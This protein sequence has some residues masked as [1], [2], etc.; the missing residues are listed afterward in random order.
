VDIGEMK[1]A[2]INNVYQIDAS[3]KVPLHKHDSNDELFY[4]VSGSGLEILEDSE[5]ELTIGKV[6]VVPAG[7][8]HAM[9]TDTEIVVASFLIPVIKE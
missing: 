3:K 4:C 9:R 8:M 7:K 2:I 6:F 1:S 5:V